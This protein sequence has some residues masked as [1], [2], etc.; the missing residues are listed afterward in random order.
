MKS[1][2]P[3]VEKRIY[4]KDNK[5]E[6]ILNYD[7]DNLYPQRILDIINSSGTAKRSVELY[8]KFING[9]GFKDKVFYKSVVNRSGLT[10]DKLLRLVASDYAHFGGRAYHVNYNGLLQKSEVSH[11]P[12]EYCRLGTGEKLGMIA[13]YEDWECSNGKKIEV[14][15]IRWYN[16]YNPSTSVL[17]NQ[18]E[19]AGGIENFEGQ[20]YYDT[21]YVISPIDAVLEDVI[22]DKSIKEFT[23]KELQNGFNPSVIGRYSKVFEGKEGDLE[24]EAIQEDWRSFQ[25]PENTGKVFLTSGVS[26]DDFSIERLGDSGADKMY[27]ITEKR[28]KNSIIQRFGQ[29]PS[30]VGRRDQNVVFSSQ[31]IEDDTKFYNSVTKDERIMIEEDFKVLFSNF[32]KN[33]NTTNDYSIIELSF[34]KTDN[35]SK[36]DTL[37]ADG[38]QKVLDIVSNPNLMDAQ[39][40]QLLILGLGFTTDE[41]QKIVIGN[42]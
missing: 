25:G 12:F 2:V 14:D 33:A 5:H 23:R 42:I 39:K 6:S 7:S 28:V 13:V 29:P 32:Y 15:K 40:I 11:I 27:D 26:K 16:R 1:A 30:L 24:W 3:K 10:A 36:F 37:K 19:K 20:I 18:I 31:N 22:S 35:P 9:E 34:D 21:K 17:L 4:N 38:F 8:A 41:A